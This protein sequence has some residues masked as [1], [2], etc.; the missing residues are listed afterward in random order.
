MWEIVR[1]T[2]RSSM[3]F[4]NGFAEIKSKA[5]AAAEAKK[6]GAGERVS[7]TWEVNTNKAETPDLTIYLGTTVTAYATGAMGV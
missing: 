7:V 1:N 5:Q 3:S 2:N 6:R 4:Y